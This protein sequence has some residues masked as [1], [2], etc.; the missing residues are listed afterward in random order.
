MFNAALFAAIGVFAALFLMIAGSVGISPTDISKLTPTQ[1]TQAI[2]K[3]QKDKFIA[4]KARG[5]L[6]QEAKIIAQEGSEWNIYSAPDDKEK[7]EEVEPLPKDFSFS[8]GLFSLIKE[9]FSL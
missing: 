5:D 8:N 6:S 4:A 1:V 3:E 9:L 2:H 7:T